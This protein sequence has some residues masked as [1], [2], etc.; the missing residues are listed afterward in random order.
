VDFEEAASLADPYRLDTQRAEAL[1]ELGDL[2]E[3]FV[4][5][6]ESH[7]LMRLASATITRSGGDA[8]LEVRRDVLEGLTYAHEHKRPLATPLFERALARAQE[9]HLDDPEF[10]A[11]AHSGLADVLSAQGRSEEAIEQ[12]RICIRTLEDADGAQHPRVANELSNLAAA[13][14]D[15]GKVDDALST[16]S[17]AVGIFEAAVQRGDI[18]ARSAYEGTAVQTMGE[19]LL[20]L[21]RA[22]EAAERLAR[23]HDIYRAAGEQEDQVALADNELADA[24]RLLGRVGEARAALNEATDIEH[25]V[26]GVPPETTAGTFA[27]RAKLA[28]DQGKAGAAL[29]LA[30][31]ALAL[32]DGGEPHVYELADARLLL[33]RVLAKARTRDMERSRSLAGQARDAFARLRDQHLADEAAEL[34]GP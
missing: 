8:R 29:P 32:L 26:S 30:E 24:L 22:R 5:Y 27:A 1:I 2:E 6:D 20:R 7:R 17:R 31:R 34:A 18:S 19:A 15:A 11:Y 10:V 23:A 16:A 3:A 14:L 25:K 4:H 13:Q 28:L 33:A 12:M 21:R 9:A